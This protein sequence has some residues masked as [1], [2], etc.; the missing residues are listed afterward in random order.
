MKAVIVV[1]HLPN[2]TPSR[3]HKQ[4]RRRL[5]GEE[6]SSWE[7]RYR[8][9]RKGILDKIPHVLLYWGIVIIHLDDMDVLMALLNEYSA[10]VH[11]RKVVAIK[12][13]EIILR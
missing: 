2:G 4:F 9:R 7:G 13:D 10:I 5:Y 6:T 1:F 3:V 11:V 8:Y 12:E